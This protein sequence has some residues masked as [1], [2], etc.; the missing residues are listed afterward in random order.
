MKTIIIELQVADDA[1]PLDRSHLAAL[2]RNPANKNVKIY[3]RNKI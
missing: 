2:I 1:H 3:E